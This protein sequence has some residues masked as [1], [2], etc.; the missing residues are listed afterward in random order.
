[1]PNDFLNFNNQKVSDNPN[2]KSLKTKKIFILLLWDDGFEGKY[3]VFNFRLDKQE[4][5]ELFKK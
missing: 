3:L 2:N 5:D 4:T 1:M